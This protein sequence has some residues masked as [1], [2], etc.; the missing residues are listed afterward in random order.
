MRPGTPLALDAH[1]QPKL[2]MDDHGFITWASDA[3]HHVIQ[4]LHSPKWPE[5]YRRH[6]IEYPN[7]PSYPNSNDRNAEVWFIGIL[8]FG[9]CIFAISVLWFWRDYNAHADEKK[10]LLEVSKR[11]K[12]PIGAMGML[13]YF[14]AIVILVTNWTHAER[15]YIPAG[16]YPCTTLKVFL[17]GAL[18]LFPAD[19]G[20]WVILVQQRTPRWNKIHA[21]FLSAL[22]GFWLVFGIIIVSLNKTPACCVPILWYTAI[23]YCIAQ[24][25]TAFIVFCIAIIFWMSGTR[26]Y[27]SMDD[28]ISE[29]V[30]DMKRPM[31]DKISDTGEMAPSYA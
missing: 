29:V 19:L 3:Y 26:K 18:I 11:A 10:Q 7:Y 28:M 31:D 25:L 8:A 20:S 12:F 2:L 9:S 14:G 1:G 15:Q 5:G 30:D 6:M 23:L 27:A 4:L 22:D 24:G 16:E 17:L 21:R 13:L